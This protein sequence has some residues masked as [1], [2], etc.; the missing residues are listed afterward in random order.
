MNI[1]TTF[2]KALAAVGLAG[3]SIYAAEVSISGGLDADMAGDWNNDESYFEFQSNNELDL[4]LGVQFSENVTVE[5][6]ATTVTGT[7]PYGGGAVEDR[8]GSFDFDGL[9]LLW[10]VSDMLSLSVGDLVFY[11]GGP[12]Y[13]TYKTYASVI[14]E[15]FTRGVQFDVSG[16]SFAFG[17]AD[18]TGAAGAP[19]VLDAYLAY[20]LESDAFMLKP[21]AFTRIDQADDLAI[22]AGVSTSVS[23]GD[24]GVDA[25]VGI[26]KVGEGDVATS[27]LV[28]PSIGMGDMSVAGSFYYAI[29]PDDGSTVGSIPEEGYFYVE[30]GMSLS[31]GF[32]VGLPLEFHLGAKDVDDESIWVVPT[33]YFYPAEDVEWW[34]WAGAVI[35]T[36][37]DGETAFSI[38]SEVIASF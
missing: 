37:D 7:L 20:T 26:N 6:Y 11:E 5:A 21:F 33:A 3:V 38:G 9:T 36:Y 30:P 2:T 18:V 1:R 27:I 17:S 10:D 12:S 19:T 23:A 22:A 15:T 16:L 29:L 25:T 4:T 14:P 32:A 35:P 28:E 24:L 31:D 13:Y 8:W 34:V